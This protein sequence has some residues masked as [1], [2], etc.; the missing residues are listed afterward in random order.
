[1]FKRDVSILGTKNYN[2]FHLE[3]THQIITIKGTSCKDIL[4]IDHSKKGLATCQ[5]AKVFPGAC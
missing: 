2:F 4:T 3:K 5:R 1:M